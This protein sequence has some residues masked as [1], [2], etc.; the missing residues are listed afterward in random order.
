M[1]KRIPKEWLEEG[2]P[3]LGGQPGYDSEGNPI[4]GDEDAGDTKKDEPAGSGRGK[5]TT[6]KARNRTDA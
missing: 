3:S 6:R 4:G 5:R 1:D 2:H